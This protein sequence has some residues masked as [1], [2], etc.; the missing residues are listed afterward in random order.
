M[1]PQSIILRDETLRRRAIGLIQNLD[2]S[3]DW[4][5]TIE[6]RKKK[7][8]LNQNA[9]YWKWLEEVVTAVQMDTGN[10]REAIHEV[11]KR[12]FLPAQVEEVLGEKVEKRTTTTLTTAE[13]SAYM[14]AIYAF[15]TSEL[16]ILLPL[17]EE[18]TGERRAA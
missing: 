5:V 9:L 16:G 1:K 10:S 3:K 6:P 13:M 4:Q 14:D 2:L 18:Y 15:V 11:F 17:P 8:T 12:K 7:R